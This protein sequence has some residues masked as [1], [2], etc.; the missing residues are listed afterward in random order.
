MWIV[1]L[2]IVGKMRY[3]NRLVSVTVTLSSVV[4]ILCYVMLC[5]A[6]RGHESKVVFSVLLSCVLGKL[7]IE[8]PKAARGHATRT[9][10]EIQH[11]TV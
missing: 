9:D 11:V 10:G 2:I 7:C 6:A 1:L 8:P 4:R 3:M 5:N